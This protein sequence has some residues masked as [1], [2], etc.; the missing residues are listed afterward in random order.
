[1]IG[2]PLNVA[3]LVLALLG[4]SAAALCWVTLRRATQLVESPDSAPKSGWIASLPW[5][6][7]L[8]G[9][10]DESSRSR[11][12]AESDNETRYK[13]L[14]ENVPAAVMLHQSDG[15]ILWG[16]PF[17]EVLTGFSLSEIL[18]NRET[19]LLNQ[20]HEEDKRLVE[21]SLGIVRTGEP[22]QYRYRFYHKSGMTLWLETRTV[23]I[24]DSSVSDYIALSITLD[25]TSAV[26]NQLQIEERNR[27][28]NE[29]TYMVS[30]DLKNPINTI[31]GMIGIIQAEP[32][33][34]KNRAL[35]QA[36][37]YIASAALRL[38]DLTDGVLKLARVSASERSLEPVD[39][40]EVMEEVVHDFKH[41]LERA[42]GKLTTIEE[43]PLVLG[44]R[45]QLYQIFSNL[46]GN[47]IKYR[48]PDRPLLISVVPERGNSR[49]RA[50][51][52]VRDNGRGIAPSHLDEIFKPF[53][54]ASDSSVGGLGVGLACVQRLA[55]RLGGTVGVESK[56]GEGSTFTVTLR[57]SPNA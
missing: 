6:G 22:F 53:H 45:T 55:S 20:V 21:K 19:F 5:V 39:L 42:D 7:R 14:T 23:P 48:A 30:H 10:I 51:I 34:K 47:A 52:V 11:R 18:K 57:K 35:D 36:A 17:T 50:S 31:K 4:L 46:I 25:V 56:E 49:R 41:Q 28:L 9:R 54:R 44:N 13:I 8:L 2:E 32:S 24:Y 33:L 16:S 43:L 37:S 29:F 3:L 26:L 12:Q 15:M 38:E 27:D 40:N 1:M